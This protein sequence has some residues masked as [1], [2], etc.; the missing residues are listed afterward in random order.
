MAP[1]PTPAVVA[2]TTTITTRPPVSPEGLSEAFL[3]G[4]WA[5]S[6]TT[7]TTTPAP[8]TTRIER[9]APTTTTTTTT[10]PP[11]LEERIE[12]LL[13][14]L[15]ADDAWLAETVERFEWTITDKRPCARDANGCFNG[16]TVEVWRGLERSD[17]R[18]LG[19][20]VVHE[21]AHAYD[22]IGGDAWQDVIAEF[23][24]HYS[25]CRFKTHPDLDV[26]P[27]MRADALTAVTLH[28]PVG[29][30]QSR[31]LIECTGSARRGPVPGELVAM[32]E[33]AVTEVTPPATLAP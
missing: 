14:H 23:S 29:G 21:Y 13:A 25:D 11:P 3:E 6:P 32:I 28:R 31:E 27:E 18:Q 30:Y 4:T 2:S 7:T 5:S 1:A 19:V 20:V 10:V 12:A 9:A 15:S 22:L 16:S 24:A 26:A 8:A 17:D 33:N